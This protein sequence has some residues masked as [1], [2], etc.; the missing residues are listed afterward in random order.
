M[1]TVTDLYHSGCIGWE[2]ITLRLEAPFSEEGADRERETYF[3][4]IEEAHVLTQPDGARLDGP[5]GE[6]V[7]RPDETHTRIRTAGV[8]A[9]PFVDLMHVVTPLGAEISRVE[10]ERRGA[11]LREL[12]RELPVVLIDLLLSRY[13]ADQPW[14]QL[15]APGTWH[16][17][18]V[19]YGSHRPDSVQVL[20]GDPD[21]ARDT[22]SRPASAEFMLPPI[23]ELELRLRDIFSLKHV[24]DAD[25]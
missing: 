13:W 23:P 8:R 10:R 5:L 12:L 15:L 6:S 2:P 7:R 9:L 19:S 20:V 11:E 18:G 21:G 25:F 14:A 1:K 16:V 4:Y 17:L 3:V 24:P 22:E